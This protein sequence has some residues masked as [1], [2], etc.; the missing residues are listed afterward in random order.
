[1]HNMK[2]L[3]FVKSTSLNYDHAIYLFG[4]NVIFSIMSTGQPFNVRIE[5]SDHKAAEDIQAS[6]S[7][8]M[9]IV[10]D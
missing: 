5:N 6:Q 8:P 4:Y 10:T 2:M 7:Y 9:H 3:H 1:M